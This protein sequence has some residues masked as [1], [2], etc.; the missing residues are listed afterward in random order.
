[1]YDNSNFSTSLLPLVCFII[2]IILD[3]LVSV[4]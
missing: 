3:I 2:I 4:K 1:M